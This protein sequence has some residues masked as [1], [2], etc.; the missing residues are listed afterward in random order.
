VSVLDLNPPLGPVLG[1]SRDEPL[2]RLALA[3]RG[4]RP[5]DRGELL[6][7]AA[8]PL[9]VGLKRLGRG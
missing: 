5:M 9:L 1:Q 3:R 4:A 2:G 8:Q 7:I 6:D